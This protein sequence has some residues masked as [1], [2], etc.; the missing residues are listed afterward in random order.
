MLQGL[1]VVYTSL[2]SGLSVF[3]FTAVLC[4][5][6]LFSSGFRYLQDREG[7]KEKKIQYN[8][9]MLIFM[10]ETAKM[11]IL[12]IPAEHTV[13]M[14]YLKPP[15]VMWSLTQWSDSTLYISQLLYCSVLQGVLWDCPTF[16][17]TAALHYTTHTLNH[18]I[19]WFLETPDVIKAF[20]F[21]ACN[22]K[23]LWC[24]P[25]QLQ[26]HSIKTDVPH[27]VS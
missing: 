14:C 16:N 22:P 15:S 21:S 19:I 26:S 27:V 3:F 23:T 25:L 10:S 11:K 24:F 13:L 7:R 8:F 20:L 9:L 1:A 18:Y 12:H 6:F 4:F 17:H 2:N 5:D